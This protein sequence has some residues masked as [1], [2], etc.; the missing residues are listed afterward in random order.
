MRSARAVGAA[1]VGRRKP[2]NI[3]FALQWTARSRT[4][5]AFALGREHGFLSGQDTKK[6]PKKESAGLSPAETKAGYSRFCA[7]AEK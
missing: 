2:E 7:A 6:E 4:P 3:G 1:L 5:P